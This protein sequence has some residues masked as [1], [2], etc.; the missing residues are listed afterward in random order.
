MVKKLDKEL[1]PLREIII[2]NSAEFISNYKQYNKTKSKFIV[3]CFT[4]FG[5]TLN[6]YHKNSSETMTRLL[7]NLLKIESVS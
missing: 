4:N 1:Q 7:P 6:E 2:N 3:S 5:K